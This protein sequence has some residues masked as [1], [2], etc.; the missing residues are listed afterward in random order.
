M[1]WRR[2]RACARRRRRRRRWR[3]RINRTRIRTRVSAARSLAAAATPII[4]IDNRSRTVNP[5]HVW[6]YTCSL[7]LSPSSPTQPA[8][9]SA[10]IKVSLNQWHHQIEFS[11]CERVCAYV[12]RPA[13]AAQITRSDS[14]IYMRRHRKDTRTRTRAQP[15]QNTTISVTS[16]L[17]AS[18][19]S[20]LHSACTHA[21]RF[22]MASVTRAQP[23]TKCFTFD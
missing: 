2:V 23:L 17:G 10:R 15:P 1:D 5:L 3:R 7:S 21:V 22:M 14:D 9:Q 13:A 4:Y 18:S 12:L 8:L 11:V 16:L 20:R 6:A 19:F